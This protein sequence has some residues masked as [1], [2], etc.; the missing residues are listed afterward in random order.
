MHRSE[1]ETPNKTFTEF[2]SSY[3]CSEQDDSFSPFQKHTPV[4]EPVFLTCSVRI[5]RKGYRP[6]Q[7]LLHTAESFFRSWYSLSLSRHSRPLWHP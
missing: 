2:R 1:S 4:N 3:L 7:I 5:S 6:T